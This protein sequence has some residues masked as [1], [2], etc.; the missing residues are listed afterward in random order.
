MSL[1]FGFDKL[2]P[3]QQRLVGLQIEARTTQI[4]FAIVLHKLNDEFSHNTTGFDPR[5]VLRL[6]CTVTYFLV[7][8]PPSPVRTFTE[9]IKL[10][11]KDG[12]LLA[13]HKLSIFHL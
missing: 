3:I 5:K 11:H 1:C 8:C 12:C 9:V 13:R 2:G 4:V 7:V 10:V 6:D